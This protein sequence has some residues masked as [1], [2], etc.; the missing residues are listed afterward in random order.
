LDMTER[1]PY[2]AAAPIVRRDD[3]AILTDAA[4]ECPSAEAA[5]RCAEQMAREP[6]H[7]GAWAFARTGYPAIGWY[8]GLR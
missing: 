1:A 5:I 3:G 6:G 2:Y 7:V 4:V 8:E